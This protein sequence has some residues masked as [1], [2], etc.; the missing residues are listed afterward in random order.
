[1]AL[2]SVGSTEF[3]PISTESGRYGLNISVAGAKMKKDRFHV[4]G[5]NGNYIIRHG[6]I[7]RLIHLHLAYVGLYSQVLGWIQEDRNAWETAAQTIQDDKGTQFEGCNLES[8]NR[9]GP[10]KGFFNPEGSGSVYVILEME[11]IFEQD[12]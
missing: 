6:R 10:P 1:M 4:P 5:T 2:F 12:K 8:F 9:L 7:G 3:N 11:A